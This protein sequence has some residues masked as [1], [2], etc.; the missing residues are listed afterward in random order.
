MARQLDINEFNKIFS[1]ITFKGPPLYADGFMP[2]MPG[3]I[4]VGTPDTCCQC[5]VC[6]LCNIQREEYSGGLG[7]IPGAA[8]EEDGPENPFP[9]DPQPI[10]Q[11]TPIRTYLDD[12]TFKA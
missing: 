1:T 11:W 5:H 7:G 6:Q 2:Q 8:Y 4:A 3:E 10:E 12:L 9:T